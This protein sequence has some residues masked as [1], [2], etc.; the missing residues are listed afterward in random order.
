MSNFQLSLLKNL[1]FPNR[2]KVSNY[3][4]LL[5]ITGKMFSQA[6]AIKSL[7]THQILTAVM[8]LRRVESH[9]SL[10]K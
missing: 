3:R 5:F 8:L 6:S 4:G 10:K 7:K 2:Q 1:S 9:Y